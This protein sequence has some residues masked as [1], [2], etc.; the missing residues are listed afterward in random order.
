MQTQWRVG[1]SGATGLDYA[2]VAA[3]LAAVDDDP[4]S[5]REA[6]ECLRAAERA[7]LAVWAEKA[8]LKRGRARR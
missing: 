7:V 4:G 8:E 2:G 1:M 3:Y 5:R 6:F